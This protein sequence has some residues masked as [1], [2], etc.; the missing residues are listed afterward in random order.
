MAGVVAIYALVD[1]RS[2][3]TR[4]IGKANNV[5]ARLKSHI[6]DSRH[7]DTP[8]YRWIRK[9]KKMGMNPTIKVLEEHQSENWENAERRCIADAIANGVRLLNVAEGGNQPFCPPEIQSKNARTA[10]EKRP[11]YVM[12][13]YRTMESMIRYAKRENLK[14]TNDLI[15]KYELFKS[16][17]YEIRRD[18]KLNL[19]DNALRDHFSSIGDNH[20]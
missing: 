3:E 16:K 18:G 19:L 13:A 5:E 17:V 10:V 8:V 11:K 2:G 9:L 12:I 7:R 4:Y 15:L 6:R 14:N 20:V 1:P